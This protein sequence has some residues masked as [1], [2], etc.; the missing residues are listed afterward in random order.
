MDDTRRDAAVRVS[1][2]ESFEH[3]CYL[4]LCGS[5]DFRAAMVQCG[6]DALL[7][8]LEGHAI[9]R[10]AG[11]DDADAE[12]IASAFRAAASE[13]GVALPTPEDS[14]SWLIRRIENLET[15]GRAA[16][17]AAETV[18]SDRVYLVKHML[19]GMAP[20]KAVGEWLSLLDRGP[21]D[22]GQWLDQLRELAERVGADPNAGVTGGA[23]ADL[24]NVLEAQAYGATSQA[25]L[26]ALGR[27]V[28]DLEGRR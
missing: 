15:V 11:A 17:R 5:D 18:F 9:V 14:R 8:G 12:E 10:L 21:D 7:D 16:P 24:T 3:A 27:I 13:A 22:Y 28:A 25:H 6:V 26:D 20:T 19:M 4:R 23:V 2:R 1:V